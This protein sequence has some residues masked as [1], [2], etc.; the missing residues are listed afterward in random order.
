MI[1]SYYADLYKENWIHIYYKLFRRDGRSCS[2]KC[3]MEQS[4]CNSTREA[5]AKSKLGYEYN[6][7]YYYSKYIVAGGTKTEK[8]LQ[9]EAITSNE[10][11]NKKFIEDNPDLF[12]LSN[13]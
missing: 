3:A 4:Y 5:L 1:A 6:C 2:S 12:V 10:L 11:E 7:G 8:E 9:F 13:Y